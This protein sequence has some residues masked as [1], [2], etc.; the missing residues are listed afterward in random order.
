[1]AGLV[2]KGTF[3]RLVLGSCR[4]DLCSALACQHF[5]S[6]YRGLN[7]VQPHIPSRYSQQH[8]TLKAASL[9]MP[10]TVGMV[11]R[12]YISRTREAVFCSVQ[13]LS[14]VWLLATPWTHVRVPCPSPTP[15]ACSNACPLSQWCHPTISSS[16][17][18]F[19]SCPQ[20]YLFSQ[21]QK[22]RE[23]FF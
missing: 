6:L 18:L 2:S 14:C 15:G 5:E 17:I 1:M 4:L 10:L 23:K 13:S 20:K 3:T 7:G 12:S 9:K 21:P 8:M 16:A 11:G 22:F 19:S